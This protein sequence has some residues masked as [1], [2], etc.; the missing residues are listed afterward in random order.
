MGAIVGLGFV[1]FIV[2][3]AIIGIAVFL[4]GT[5]W[6]VIYLCTRKS[7]SHNGKKIKK[8]FIVLPIGLIAIGIILAIPGGLLT[9]SIINDKIYKEE[10]P[11]T[12]QHAAETS[13][14]QRIKDLL[15]N[16]VNPDECYRNS[17]Y[18]P[19]MFACTHEHKDDYEIAKLLLEHGA[20]P[21]VEDGGSQYVD[22]GVQSTEGFTPLMYASMSSQKLE[23]V[24]LLV[25]YGADVSHASVVGKTALSI[26]KEFQ[27]YDIEQYLLEKG[28]T[29]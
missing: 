4:T 19:L 13:N 7:R 9:T 8:V 10:Y 1:V 17:T 22:Y 15:E 14:I 2:I 11:K 3:L 26:A 6:L 23:L 29:H 27:N 24:K 18:T 25:G 21:N 16:G 5:I 12:I 20:N 28:A